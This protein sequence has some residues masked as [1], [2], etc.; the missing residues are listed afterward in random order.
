MRSTTR[1]CAPSAS[2]CIPGCQTSSW[3]SPPARPIHRPMSS[4]TTCARRSGT[5]TRYAV[6]PRRARTTSPRRHTENRS[7]TARR[8]SRCS[9]RSAMRRRAPFCG[10]QLLIQPASR[11]RD[12]RLRRTRSGRDVSPGARALRRSIGARCPLS[13]R[14]RSPGD[15]PPGARRSRSGPRA[16]VAMHVAGRAGGA[17]RSRDRCLMHS[18]LHHALLRAP[19]RLPCGARALSRVVPR[20]ARRTVFLPGA[21]GRGLRRLGAAADGG[22]AHGGCRGG[23]AGDRRGRRARGALGAPV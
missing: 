14:S 11:S 20:R 3:G 21:P 16:V 8:G 10:R 12:E 2:S 7:G 9:T 19:S 5:R 6:S 18:R 13:G 17:A 4:P 1:S 15:V 22:V 23:R